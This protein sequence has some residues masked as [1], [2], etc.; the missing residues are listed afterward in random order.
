MDQERRRT[1]GGLTH[2]LEIGKIDLQLLDTALTHP[3][4]A[5]EHHLD[6]DNQRL[7]FLGDAVVDLLMGE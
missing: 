2:K 4:Y 1:L 6:A 3:S 7:E 5:M